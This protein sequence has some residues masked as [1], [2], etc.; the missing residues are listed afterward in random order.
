MIWGTGPELGLLTICGYLLILIGAAMAWR[1]R[2]NFL[3]WVQDEICIFRRSFSRFIPVGPFYFPRAESRVKEVPNYI[4]NSSL[5]FVRNSVQ[6]GAFLLLIGL[7]LFV[8]DFYIR[9]LAR[10]RISSRSG[11]MEVA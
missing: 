2:N 1:S 5:R 9:A 6:W 8:L 11:Q 7:L 4:L 3:V 10:T